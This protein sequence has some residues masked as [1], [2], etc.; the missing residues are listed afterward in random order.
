MTVRGTKVEREKM[1][2]EIFWKMSS[3]IFDSLNF[4]TILDLTELE[5]ELKHRLTIE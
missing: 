2:S 1:D 5:T 3:I 4:L